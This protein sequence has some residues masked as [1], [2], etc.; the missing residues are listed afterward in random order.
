[1]CGLRSARISASA[2][3]ARDNCGGSLWLKVPTAHVGY[4]HIEVYQFGNPANIA[5][6]LKSPNFKL[7]HED[8]AVF[9]S[10]PVVRQRWWSSWRC[11]RRMCVDS[12]VPCS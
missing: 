4:A 12:R 10:D 2:K 1:L 3:A 6:M 11:P 8:I 5:Q 7:A 9:D